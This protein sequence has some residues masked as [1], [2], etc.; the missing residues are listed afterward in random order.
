MPK[1]GPLRKKLSKGDF[2]TL[3]IK[4]QSCYF[5][6]TSQTIEQIVFL[7]YNGSFGIYYVIHKNIFTDIITFTSCTERLA[8]HILA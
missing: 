3:I 5:I 8:F 6:E 7:L 4:R 2:V 1:E